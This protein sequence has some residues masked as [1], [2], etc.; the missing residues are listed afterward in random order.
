MKR[1]QIL[2]L[3]LPVAF[4]LGACDAK[5]VVGECDPDISVRVQAFLDTLEVVNTVAGGINAD[6]F[7]A[8]N[9]IA[10]GAGE[11][12]VDAAGAQPTGEEVRSAC[13]AA[14]L[15][16]KASLDAGVSITLA[17]A[18]P[19]CTI[20]AQ[21]SVDCNA[22][23]DVSGECTPG[24]VD[25]ECMGGELSVSCE[26]TCEGE[27][28]CDASVTAECGATCEGTCTG[29][30][31]GGCTGT[32]ECT[33]SC[34]G[35]C[36]GTAE[37][38]GACDG[39]CSVALDQDG[40]CM[41]ECDGTCS[42]AVSCMGECKGTCMAAVECT[43]SC[44]ASCTGSCEG[45]CYVEAEADCGADVRCEGSCMGTATAPTC[46]GEVVP[47]MCDIDAQCSAGCDAQASLE[48][49]CTEPEVTVAIDGSVD[50]NLEAALVDNMPVILSIGAKGL[51]LA[52]SAGD[53]LDTFG[54]VL[55]SAA[56]QLA[57]A[58]EFG[59]EILTSAQASAQAAI[60]VNVS[61]QASVSVSACASSGDDC[62]MMSMQ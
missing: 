58:T 14:N 21:A 1:Y 40:N 13:S 26:G 31:E 27:I 16:L 60:D 28:Y 7:E 18:P 61:F 50:A 37:C 29:G 19:V 44:D 2:M 53:V 25:I 17:Y 57:C 10:V 42:V 59:A 52:E 30:C 48:A 34:E 41:G 45:K 24:M 46:S 8:C 20:D 15:A 56:S 3:A 38:M 35:S 5:D 33:G 36:T 47:P 4:G 39:T 62:D 9:N 6:V 32:A 54:D 51:L 12:A 43:G 23:C 49:S 22:R 11:E 55:G